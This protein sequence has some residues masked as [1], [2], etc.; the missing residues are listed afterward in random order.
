MKT[1]IKLSTFVYKEGA[2]FTDW[3]G[4]QSFRE[5]PQ[6]MKPGSFSLDR[7]ME[8]VTAPHTGSKLGRT[9]PIQF[10]LGARYDA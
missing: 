6:R 5:F 2:V 3:C 4:Q 7:V 8:S 9:A 1:H 10:S